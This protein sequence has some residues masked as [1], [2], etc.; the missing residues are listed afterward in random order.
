M[1]WRPSHHLRI[2]QA[3]DAVTTA[4]SFVIAFSLWDRF[5]RLTEI[6]TPIRVTTN[7]FTLIF[8]F[9][10][11]WVIIFNMLGAYSYQRFTS[12]WKELTNVVKTTFIGVCVFFAAHYFL[13]FGNIPRTYILAFTFVNLLFLALEKTGLFYLAKELRKRG[14]SRK[15]VIIVGTGNKTREFIEVLKKNI[16][17]GLD[18]IGLIS[19]KP[20]W[21]EKD[22]LG[23]PILGGLKD[24]E[25]VL[26]SH[27]INEVIICL[28]SNQFGSIRVAL[29]CC[30]KE[31]V[32]VRIFS[33]VFGPIV[34]SLQIDQIYGMKIISITHTLDREV[35]LYIK[36]LIDI[37]VSGFLLILLIPLFVI[38][39]IL[40]KVT[41]RGPIFY[42]LN[43]VGKDRKPIKGNKFRTMVNNAELFQDQ[44][45]SKNEMKGPVF[46]IKNDPRITRVGKFL[47]KYSLDELPQL[48]CVFVG[49]LSLVGPRPPLINEVKKYESWHRRRLSV[50]PG[51]TCLWQV[52]GRQKISDFDSWTNMDMEY[53][54]N[55]TLRLDFKILLKTIPVI[56]RGTGV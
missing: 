48:W 55:W 34:K 9:S 31:G 32:Q 7:D 25:K 16:G 13:R 17:L 15:R 53:I 51:L 54:D 5:R 38:I 39:S 27:I 14:I 52:N 45:Q 20:V 6:S 44:L 33:D 10:L 35:D 1:I 3:A 23:Y 18:I 50:K 42:H 12:L 8:G 21:I 47:R 56:F 2:V 49:D 24:F 11:L 43:W 36:R 37:I 40:I 22:I 41:S 4:G 46:K 30:E 29:D 19:E 28:L 26:H